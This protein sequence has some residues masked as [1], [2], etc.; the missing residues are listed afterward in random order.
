[1]GSTTDVQPGIVLAKNSQAE[2]AQ[3]P[4]RKASNDTMK[5]SI[6]ISRSGNTEKDVTPF[7][8]SASMRAILYFVVP[9]CLSFRAL[10]RRERRAPIYGNSDKLRDLNEGL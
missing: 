6:V 7:N 8:P 5:P 1:M 10:K 9:A 4:A 2:I 3:R